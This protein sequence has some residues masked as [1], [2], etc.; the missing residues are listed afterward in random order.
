MGSRRLERGA[1]GLFALL[2]LAAG[3][4]TVSVSNDYDRSVDF[5]RFHTFAVAGGRVFMNG[6]S[7]DGNT[8]LKD[9]IHRA[10]SAALTSKGL[11]E[12]TERPDLLVGY[13]AGARTRTEIE[14]MPPYAPEMGPYWYGGWWGPGYAEW[15]TRTYDEGTLVID[16]VDQATH[17]LVW[18]AYARAEV[19]PPV[20]DEK[21]R[22]AVEKAFKAYP[23]K[24]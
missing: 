17:K 3:C 21:I 5:S 16:L 14:G 15:W 20:S 12:T 4:A 13:L 23:P 10:V 2:V 19:K 8:L 9:R 18:R 22:A 7:D 24:P 6:I 11:T 1:R